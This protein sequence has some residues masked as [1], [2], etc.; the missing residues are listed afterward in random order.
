MRRKSSAEPESSKWSS[1]CARGD[2]VVLERAIT[3][4][5]AQIVQIGREKACQ[6]DFGSSGVAGCG[7]LPARGTSH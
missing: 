7:R 3:A 2:V 5:I 6:A 1:P 4:C